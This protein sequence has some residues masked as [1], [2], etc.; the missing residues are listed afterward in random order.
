MGVDW[1]ILDPSTRKYII[2]ERICGSP[3]LSILNRR[4]IEASIDYIK[5]NE[6]K[7]NKI[8]LILDLPITIC[9]I[10]FDYTVSLKSVI[11]KMKGWLI[12]LKGKSKLA[13]A[14][15]R[16]DREAHH[17]NYLMI[18]SVDIS[19]DLMSIDLIGLLYFVNPVSSEYSVEETRKIL[20]MYQLIQPF[21]DQEIDKNYSIEIVTVLKASIKYNLPINI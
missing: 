8:E 2:C 11:Y 18:E 17:I 1:K 4:W 21:L 14:R 7:I 9:Q 10:I 3:S 13:R 20:K 15:S 6:N 12:P 19:E 16:V 5:Y